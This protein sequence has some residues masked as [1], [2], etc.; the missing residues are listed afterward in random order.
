M[1]GVV[2][3]LLIF[4]G[5][6]YPQFYRNTFLSLTGKMAAPSAN[7]IAN[8][9]QRTNLNYGE[10]VNRHAAAFGLSPKYLK[11]L[12]ILESSGRKNVPAR[13]E[14]HVYRRLKKLKAGQISQFENLR[15]HHLKDASD[16]ALKNLARSWGPF[17]IMGYKCILLGINIKDLRGDKAVFWGIKWIDMTYGDY[18]RKGKYMDC[19]HLHNTG[20]PY[21][22][23]GPPKTYDPNYVKNGMRYMGY[24]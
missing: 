18:L 2:I 19:F 20:K 23:A 3:V 6:K 1:L 13:F 16:A 17:Q 7:T 12:I 22:K 24:F 21:P 15:P 11:A 8:T 14:K 9:V 10:A 5:V 4:I